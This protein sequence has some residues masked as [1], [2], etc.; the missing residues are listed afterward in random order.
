MERESERVDLYRDSNGP[1]SGIYRCTIATSAVHDD[2]NPSLGESM[3]VGLY[4]I[5]GKISVCLG[6]TKFILLDSVSFIMV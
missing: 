3:Y 4:T 5:G 2:G 6:Q 1:T